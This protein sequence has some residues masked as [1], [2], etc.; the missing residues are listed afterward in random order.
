MRYSVAKGDSL[1]TIARD[2]LGDPH[3]WAEIARLNLI[4]PPYRLLVGEVHELPTRFAGSLQPSLAGAGH[5]PPAGPLLAGRHWTHDADRPAA[6]IPARAYL[7]V[8]ADEPASSGRAARRVF[9]MPLTSGRM[10]ADNLVLFGLE[11]GAGGH[12]ASAAGGPRSPALEGAG[13]RALDPQAAQRLGLTR[14]EL[15]DLRS[16]LDRL[17]RRNPALGDR[18]GRLLGQLEPDK[19]PPAAGSSAPAPAREDGQGMRLAEVIGLIVSAYDLGQPDGLS[20]RPTSPQELAPARIRCMAGWGGDWLGFRLA[21]LDGTAVAIEAG[22]GPVPL[23]AL[24]GIAFG[25]S[26]EAGVPEFV[27]SLVR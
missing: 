22:P 7:L 25:T 10:V 6:A 9:S 20:C 3:R 24:G 19:A 5:A 17:A 2:R 16:D 12:N 23:A 13:T 4:V 15:A 27:R 8:V 11:P 18:I 21:G 26:R 14:I 1:V